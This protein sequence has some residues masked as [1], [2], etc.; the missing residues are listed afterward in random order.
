M[1]QAKLPGLVRVREVEWREEMSV[2]AET[3]V[4]VWIDGTEGKAGGR[5]AFHSAAFPLPTRV[6]FHLPTGHRKIDSTV[7]SPF[8]VTNAIFAPSACI[9]AYCIYT[10][11]PVWYVLPR[12]RR[13]RR[14]V[15]SV[16]LS[17][18]QRRR[19]R[20]RLEK[21]YIKSIAYTHSLRRNVHVQRCHIV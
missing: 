8:Y 20:R 9:N 5:V 18:L 21:I 10:T 14:R 4:S 2:M 7:T 19:R 16:L 3:C 11:T 13:R 1:N 17:N 15:P 12:R 6:F